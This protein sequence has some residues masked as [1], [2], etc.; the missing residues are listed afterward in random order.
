M[1]LQVVNSPFNQEQ[2]ELL[3]RLLPQLTETQQIWLGGYLTARQIGGAINSNQVVAAVSTGSKLQ[4]KSLR[5]KQPF[6][7]VPRREIPN[8]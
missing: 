1:A 6:S 3:N 5:A 2:V 8:L 4:K 7:L